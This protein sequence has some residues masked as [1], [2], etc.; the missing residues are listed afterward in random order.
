M[1]L[2]F[3]N[4][5][6]LFLSVGLL[7]LLN[8]LL[9]RNLRWILLLI[10]SY[11][12]YFWIGSWAILVLLLSTVLNYLAGLLLIKTSG[13][14]RRTLL[15]SGILLNVLI[16]FFFKYLVGILAPDSTLVSLMSTSGGSL[17][18]PVGL[19]F[20]TLQNIS[21]LIDVSKG[22]IQ[23]E[24]NPGIFALYLAFF[25]K[26]LSGPI[27]RSGKL[28]PQL[29]YPDTLK[30]ENI[31][32]GARLML[33]GLFKKVVI[34]DRLAFY[35]NEV[36]D[37]PGEYH[38]WTVIIALVFL[39]FQI[40]MDFS[41]YT[42]LALGAARVFGIQL[43]PNFKRP[44]FSRNIMEFW[45]RWHLSFSTWLRDY[46]FYPLRRFLLQKYRNSTGFWVLIIPPLVTMLLSGIWHGVGWTFILW[47]MYHAIFY[48]LVVL[49][50]SRR[51]KPDQEDSWIKNVTLGLV[52]F[53]VLSLS[54]LLFRAENMT[55]AITIFRNILVPGQMRYDLHEI[56]R[57][58]YLFDF[59]WARLLI[60]GII[61]VEAFLE[62][63]GE[64]FVFEK[65]SP[66]LRWA[67][68]LV[69]L[70]AVTLFGV[71]SRGENSFVYFK[72]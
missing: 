17:I 18:V 32:A 65:A 60:L 68:Y 30:M 28:I 26:V 50:K 13:T 48:V 72:F 58:L 29:R 61:A 24:R 56:L 64:K 47:G 52:N 34:A 40:Y 63:R 41:G 20:Y 43:S 25:P 9:P 3:L 10:V 4:P 15:I 49:F 55:D 53:V 71:Y 11:A 36:L 23:A 33:F 7:G 14:H 54:W 37:K 12:F 67:V 46:I 57:N 45:N 31:S 62:V 66:W 27:E 1:S 21:Y 70:L 22:L 6:I 2:E 38:G 35:V 39:S 8:Y 44:Y 69:M 51:A 42:D 16:L 5:L 19:S 59:I